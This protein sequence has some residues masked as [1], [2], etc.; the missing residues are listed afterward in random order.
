MTAFTAYIGNY[1]NNIEDL[2]V[3][4]RSMNQAGPLM[5]VVA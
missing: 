5:A 3:S 1:T 4:H 2:P